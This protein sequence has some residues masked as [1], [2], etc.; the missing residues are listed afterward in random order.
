MSRDET[1]MIDRNGLDEEMEALPAA[2]ASAPSRVLFTTAYRNEREPYDYIGANSRS[3]W[4][5]FRWPRNQSFGLRFLKQNI[6]EIEITEFPTSGEYER[7]LAE[8]WDVV[9]ISFYL[10]ETEEALEMADAAR[11]SGA[12]GEVWAGN[13]GAL[14]PSIQEKFDRVFVGYA[15]NQ[16]AP[17]FNRT[18]EKIVHPPLIEH[19]DSS[20]GLKLNIYGALFT[21]RG[22]SVGCKFCQAPSFCNR[23]SPLPLESIERVLSYY[24]DHKIN[25][26]LIEDESF[27]ANRRHADM[28]VDLLDEYGMVWGCMARADYLRKKIPEWVEMRTRPDPVT[29]KKSRHVKGFAGAAIGIENL[30]QEKLDDINKKE[31]T[32]DVLET[33]RLLQKYGLGTVGYYMI[34]FPE[35][36]RQS[37]KTDIKDLAN[38][39]LDITQICIMTPL[40]QTKLWDELEEN[41]G[42]F[43]ED[44]H[45]FDMKHLVWNH[46]NIPPAE[47]EEILGWSLKQVYNRMTPLRTSFRVWAN[48]YRYAGVAGM[49]EVASY[50]SRANRFDFNPEK[51]WFLEAGAR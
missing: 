42:I 21:I 6:P 12:V 2:K 3:R 26:V 17:F 4:F 41:Y 35:D 13:Y 14:T 37:L 1:E 44:W 27:G 51:P 40:P 31:G 16:V 34:G 49:K 46:Q 22:C 29:G 18:I 50:V 30:H 11:K 25:V 15:E 20:F 7:K 19:L 43:E 10:S 9:G 23:P 8:G 33:V 28:V 48:A 24:R 38:L 39:K 32:E 5:R 47:M 36:T 45:R